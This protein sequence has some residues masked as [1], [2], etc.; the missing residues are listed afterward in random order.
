MEIFSVSILTPK[1]LSLSKK[2]KYVFIV[3][4]PRINC[5]DCIDRTNVIMARTSELFLNEV[6]FFISKSKLI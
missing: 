6:Q 2:R 4:I 3:R 5:L 1:K